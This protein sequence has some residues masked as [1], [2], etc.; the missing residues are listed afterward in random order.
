MFFYTFLKFETLIVQEKNY[1]FVQVFLVNIYSRPR[2]TC[3][4][5]EKD[6][7]G[8]LRFQMCESCFRI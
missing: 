3:L 8:V 2:Y 6:N 5:L 1:L 4:H 7:E